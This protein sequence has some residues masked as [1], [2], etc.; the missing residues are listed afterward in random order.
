MLG[1]VFPVGGHVENATDG[2]L[3]ADV[4]GEGRLYDA[5]LVVAALVPGIREEE[6]QAGE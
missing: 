3:L 5:A 2:E 4:L 6:L 1:V